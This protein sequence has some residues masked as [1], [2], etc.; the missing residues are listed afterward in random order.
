MSLVLRGFAKLRVYFRLAKRFCIIVSAI[1]SAGFS[2]WARCVSPRPHSLWA[3]LFINIWEDILFEIQPYVVSR[4]ST[5][6]AFDASSSAAAS[7]DLRRRLLSCDVNKQVYWH[8]TGQI[9]E[10]NVIDFQLN[11]A[12]CC[13]GQASMGDHHSG[14]ISRGTPTT[15]ERHG[16]WLTDC[17]WRTTVVIFF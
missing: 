2:F 3:F 11:L 15:P 6:A 10:I 8:T 9:H 7:N 14:G 13:R 12:P 4:R 5:T 16:F 17:F 1:K